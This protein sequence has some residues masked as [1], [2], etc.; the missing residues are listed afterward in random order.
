MRPTAS[1][2]WEARLAEGEHVGLGAGVEE[3]DLEETVRD[4]AWLADKL[5]EPCIG[6]GALAA[7]VGVEAVGG[8][9]RLTVDQQPEPHRRSLRSQ[10]EVEIAGV[11]SIRDAAIRPV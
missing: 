5:V 10:D 2:A 8:P 3:G 6:D 7:L 4:G 1:S 11:K 9:G